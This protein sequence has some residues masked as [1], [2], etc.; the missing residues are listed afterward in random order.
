MPRRRAHYNRI[1]AAVFPSVV[2]RLQYGFASAYNF[3]VI[4]R[5]CKI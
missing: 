4:S 2:S 3:P 1:F 5:Y